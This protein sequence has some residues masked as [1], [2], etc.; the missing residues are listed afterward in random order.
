MELDTL[1]KQILQELFRDARQTNASIGR[2]VGLTG[3]AVFHRIDR[4]EK[5]GV[6]T[7][8]RPVIDPGNLGNPL[9]AFVRVVT[10]PAPT[11]EPFQ[12]FVR[13]EPRIVECF[14]VD[15]EDSFILKV[16]CAGPTDLHGLLLDIRRQT[17]VL[18]TVTNISL[19]SVKEQW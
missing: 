9:L 16:R 12:D 5:A 4:L 11:D 8:Y 3:Q 6:I 13:S 17:T 7:G 14:D 1:D 19:L 10:R 18:R 15:G 2:V